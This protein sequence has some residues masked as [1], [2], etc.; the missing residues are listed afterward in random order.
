MKYTNGSV[1]LP[2]CGVMTLI[3]LYYILNSK[4]IVKQ[5]WGTAPCTVSLFSIQYA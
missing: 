3:L 2:E 1:F 4:I 5:H